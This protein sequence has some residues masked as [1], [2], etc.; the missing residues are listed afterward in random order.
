MKNALALLAALAATP[1]MAHH[2][3]N[4]APME[5]F[6]H[7][8]LSGIGHPILGFDHLFF[9]VL[10]GIVA[11]LSGKAPLAA[12]SYIAAMLGGCLAMSMGFGLPLIEAAI[13]ASLV[14]VG[15]AA[16]RGLSL[17]SFATVGIFAGFGLFHGMAFGESIAGAEAGLG[18]GALAGY[19]LGLGVVQYAIAIGS[20]WTLAKISKTEQDSLSWARLAGSGVAGIGIFL[21][22]EMSEGAALDMLLA[23]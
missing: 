22:L 16:V 9:I 11:A 21:I 1:A 8:L 3:L 13:A 6:T 23:A 19:L 17:S 14:V 7:G 5:T 20:G 18:T 10:M 4:G 12:G 15:V 2:P